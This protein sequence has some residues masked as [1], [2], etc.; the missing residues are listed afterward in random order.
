MKTY[1][2]YEIIDVETGELM[3]SKHY[4]KKNYHTIKIEKTKKLQN[5]NIIETTKRIVKHTGQYNIF[6]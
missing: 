4:D 5:G 3:N 6:E 2:I 1:Y